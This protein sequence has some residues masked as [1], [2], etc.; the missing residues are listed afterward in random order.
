MIDLR[1][2]IS[3][4]LLVLTI[5]SLLTALIGCTTETPVA[6][7]QDQGS[8][9]ASASGEGKTESKA[10]APENQTFAIGDKIALGDNVLTV[11]GFARSQGDN[12]FDTPKEGHEYIIIDLTIENGGSENISYNPFDF[13]MQNS[14][15][16]IL[17]G[18][19]TLTEQDKQLNSGELAP[20]GKVSG[21]IV[22]EQPKGDTGLQLIYQP[23]FWSD[24]KIKI[25][26]K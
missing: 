24:G 9:A 18:A 7:N 8:N 4:V 15:G 13:S 12:E 14:Q 19:F 17:D 22:F 23:N 25:E 3:N 21:V 6:V 16:Q 5:L 11:N 20:K 2:R 10:P 26:I 1:K